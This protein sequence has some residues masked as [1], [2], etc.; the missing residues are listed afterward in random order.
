MAA[1]AHFFQCASVRQLHGLRDIYDG[2]PT[3][4]GDME[5]IVL[6]RATVRDRQYGVQELFT[7]NGS[8]QPLLFH[9]STAGEIST[10]KNDL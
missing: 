3:R 4:Y 1:E 6:D 7:G 5:R 10:G 2:Q 9:Y 8:T